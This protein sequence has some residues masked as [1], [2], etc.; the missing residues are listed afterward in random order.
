MHLHASLFL[1]RKVINGA[2][3]HEQN[4]KFHQPIDLIPIKHN[5][6]LLN[7][8]HNSIKSFNR[9]GTGENVK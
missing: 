6:E 9:T 2:A 3:T 7:Y 8:F 1:I 5:L 4:N